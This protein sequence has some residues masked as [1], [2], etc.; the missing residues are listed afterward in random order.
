MKKSATIYLLDD[1]AS[2]RQGL[3]R[4]LLAAGY[5]VNAFASLE[6]FFKSPLTEKNACLVFDARML[7]F[8]GIDL[9]HELVEKHV[10]LPVIFITADDDR[11]TQEKARMVKA[12]G[13]FH[14][15]VDG[16]ALLDAIT[17]ALET[18]RLDNEQ[19]A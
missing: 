7:G 16:P 6:E 4:L 18:H 10:D 1:D 14:K 9:Q 2:A 15:P 8:S 17:W 3:T 11:E 13:F 12:A 5:E 19:K